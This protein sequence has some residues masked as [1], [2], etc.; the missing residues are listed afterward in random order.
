VSDADDRDRGARRVLILGQLDGFANGKWPLAAL[1]FLESCGHDPEIIDTYHLSRAGSSGLRRRVPGM[2]PAQ[3]LLFA[4]EAC[5]SLLARAGGPLRRCLSY[6]LLTA[7][8]RMR[9]SLLR[10]HLSLAGVDLLICE[11]PHDSGV[12][13]SCPVRTLYHCPTPWADELRLEG[14]LTARQHREMR[15]REGAL[16]ESADHLAFHWHT[17]AQYAVREYGI[18]G[19]NLL[20]LDWGCESVDRRASYADPPRVVYM[21]SLSSW[22]I[23]L[24]LLARLSRL[25]DIDVYGGPLPDPQYG[26][27]FRGWAPP[28]VLAEYQFGL[29]TCTDDP[30][31][32]SGFSAKHLQYFSYGLPVLLPRWRED[33]VLAAGSVAYDEASFVEVLARASTPDAWST[34]SDTAV[35][36]ARRLSWDNSL[37]PLDRLLRGE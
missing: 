2:A 26:L 30:L 9:G 1:R 6:P 16:F 22:F 29:I 14:R 33:P 5:L 11:T 25:V 12:L 32:R 27:R 18:S 20:V 8:L 31:R 10:R 3:W 23:D 34:L 24:P 21:G 7:E 19:R 35:A 15:G 4:V 28:D 36:Q 13:A 37:D 17:Y